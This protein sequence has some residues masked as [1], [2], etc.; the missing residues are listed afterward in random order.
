MVHELVIRGS[1]PAPRVYIINGDSPNAFATGRNTSY[2]AIAV[3]KGLR[4]LLNREE[5]KGVLAHEIAFV[6]NRE[7][8][9]M[10]ITAI[11]NVSQTL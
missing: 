1:I 2:A 7:A 8:L 3:T 5:A 4:C 11:L 10:T 6:R 9:V